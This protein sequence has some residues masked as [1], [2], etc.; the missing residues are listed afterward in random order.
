MKIVMQDIAAVVY[1]NHFKKKLYLFMSQ[2]LNGY[3]HINVE[4][5]FAK[6]VH[7]GI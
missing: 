6:V 5:A 3:A 2:G 7:K 1:I 4:N